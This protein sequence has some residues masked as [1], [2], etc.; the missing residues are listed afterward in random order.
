MGNK[1]QAYIKV[2]CTALLTKQIVGMTF[3]RFQE[4][5]CYPACIWQIDFV[6]KS[7]S[8]LRQEDEALFSPSRQLFCHS[9][10]TLNYFIF[11]LLLLN[12]KD[13]VTWSK[14]LGCRLFAYFFNIFERQFGLTLSIALKICQLRRKKKGQIMTFIANLLTFFHRLSLFNREEKIRNAICMQI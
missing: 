5:H 11:S 4:D 7:A 2:G 3:V 9:E 14:F 8:G 10:S 12:K 6:F 13:H 1:H